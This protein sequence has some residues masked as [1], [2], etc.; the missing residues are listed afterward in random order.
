M[1]NKKSTSR[2][3]TVKSANKPIEAEKEVKDTPVPSFNFTHVTKP[4][5]AKKATPPVEPPKVVEAKK[6]T[7]PSE[8]PAPCARSGS[9]ERVKQ[10]QAVVDWLNSTGQNSAYARRQHKLAKGAYTLNKSRSP[11]NY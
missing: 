3:S 5:E 6:A 4:V 7:T 10:W 11:Q 1:A 8:P 9:E 2:R